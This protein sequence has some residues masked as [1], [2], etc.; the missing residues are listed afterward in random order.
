[1]KTT[2]FAEYRL[3]QLML[4]TAQFGVQYGIANT[5]GQPSYEDVRGIL[6]C[7]F[8]GGVNCLD[9]SVAYGAS[10]ELIGRALQELSLAERMI[11]VRCHQGVGHSSGMRIPADGRALD[12][13]IGGPL[14]EAASDGRASG[15]P[16]S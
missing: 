4:G 3:S 7:A 16:V 8:E 9:T 15:L 2:A 14:S 5:K 1:M 10:E 12:P 6:A 13:G 11:V